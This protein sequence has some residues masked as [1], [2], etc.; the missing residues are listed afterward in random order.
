MRI[1]NSQARLTD[2]KSKTKHAEETG[3]DYAA[4]TAVQASIQSLVE[5]NLSF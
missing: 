5:G 2:E 4:N 1:T 3:Y